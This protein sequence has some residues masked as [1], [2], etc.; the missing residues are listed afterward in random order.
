M[1]VQEF[2]GFVGGPD[3]AREGHLDGRTVRAVETEV[4]APKRSERCR[5]IGALMGKI[6]R[7]IK[8]D[9]ADPKFEK[10]EQGLRIGLEGLDRLAKL[11]GHD[12]SA[13]EWLF[14]NS[15]GEPELGR[16]VSALRQIE[17]AQIRPWCE[18]AC[19]LL[20]QKVDGVALRRWGSEVLDKGYT[21]LING[22]KWAARLDNQL[23]EVVRLAMV[24]RDGVECHVHGARE[25]EAMPQAYEVLAELQKITESSSAL[26]TDSAITLDAF[27]FRALHDCIVRRQLSSADF[28]KLLRTKGD[29]ELVSKLAHALK[30]GVGAVGAMFESLASP[31]PEPLLV[32]EGLRSFAQSYLRG[33]VAGEDQNARLDFVWPQLQQQLA[34]VDRASVAVMEA[35]LRGAF[36][37]RSLVILDAE[38]ERVVDP[39]DQ[40]DDLRLARALL[41][42]WAALARNRSFGSPPGKS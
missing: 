18:K 39:R 2:M 12:K 11:K 29:L 20:D 9:P 36:V 5:S 34:S 33:R 25:F 14:G 7:L 16:L 26:Q 42:W 32:L 13:F 41:V 27:G 21:R 4:G 10:G 28:A 35:H 37:E 6:S 24:L 38:I 22:G 8:A 19:K 30:A 40:A 15:K 1:R 17:H 31:K 3:D 23:T